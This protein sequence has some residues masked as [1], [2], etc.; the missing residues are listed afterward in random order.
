MSEAFQFSKFRTSGRIIR[1]LFLHLLSKREEGLPDRRL[2]LR[3][4]I[5]RD[6][7]VWD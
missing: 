7:T 2:H 3:G 5:I 4:E 1:R 6:S